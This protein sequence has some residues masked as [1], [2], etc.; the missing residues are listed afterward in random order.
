MS[1]RLTCSATV[2]WSLVLTSLAMAQPAPASGAREVASKPVPEERA[3]YDAS[4]RR[5]PF[6]SLTARGDASLPRSGR[7]V[8]VDGLLISELSIRGVLRSNGR[9]L[10]IVQAPDQKTFTLH[11]GDALHDGAVKAVTADAVIFLQRVDDPLSPV[12]QREIRKALRTTE[13]TR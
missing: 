6:A 8:G 12:K 7:P 2:V 1:I 13:E 10:A 4:G 11:A 9:L 3:V 5:D